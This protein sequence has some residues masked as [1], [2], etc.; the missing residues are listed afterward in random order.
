M[1]EATL[2][3]AVYAKCGKLETD[4]S[5]I[6]DTDIIREYGV[7]LNIFKEK[8]PITR[9]RYIESVDETARA[10]EDRG[11]YDV[12]SLTQWVK[13]VFPW[14]AIEEAYTD[15]AMSGKVVG[16]TKGDEYYNW[17]SL[18]TIN[19]QRKQKGLPRFRWYFDRI[20][21]KLRIDP[22]PSSAGDKYWYFSAENADWMLANVPAEL[23]DLL[24]TGTVWKMIEQLAMARTR[25]GGIHKE[26][27]F[28]TYP[29]AEIHAIAKDYKKEFYDELRLKTK[30][31]NM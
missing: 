4:T 5:E 9:L 17:P 30:I 10:Y 25:L 2:L 18:W 27:G 11:E 29:A 23:G 20:R 24:I 14:G 22:Y 7:I 28:V 6:E 19:M 12:N 3:E 31:W 15:P 1:E 16:V 26:G 8:F 21:K 13:Q